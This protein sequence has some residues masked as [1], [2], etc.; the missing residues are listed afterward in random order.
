MPEVFETFVFIVFAYLRV[1]YIHLFIVLGNIHL[2][3]Q[4][5]RSKDNLW[6]SDF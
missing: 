6:E 5:Y 4:E 2:P 1:C 3:Q